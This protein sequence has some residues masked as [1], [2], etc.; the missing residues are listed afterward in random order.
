MKAIFICTSKHEEQN[1][2]FIELEDGK[3]LS[4]Q[5]IKYTQDSF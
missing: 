2:L 5:W 3:F 1:V 4:S